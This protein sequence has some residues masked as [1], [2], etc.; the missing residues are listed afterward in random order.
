MAI[1]AEMVRNLR[2]K[3]GAGM[4]ECK[5]AL[6]ESEGDMEKATQLLRERG[7]AVA[8]KRES[9]QAS[10]GIVYSHIRQ[11]GQ[12]GVLVE[13]NCE[14][15]FVARTDDFQNLAYQ[16]AEYAEEHPNASLEEITSDSRIQNEINEKVGKLG[17]RIVVKRVE[18]FEGGPNSAIASYI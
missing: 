9:K 12:V 17:E 8:A 2:E 13:L 1:T 3:T 10:E 15:D 14:T 11:D 5:K 6:N 16:I 7:Q 18:V 4:M